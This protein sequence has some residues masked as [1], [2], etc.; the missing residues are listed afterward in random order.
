MKKVNPGVFLSFFR[1]PKIEKRRISLILD[2]LNFDSKG[3]VP[4]Q[5]GTDHNF[6]GSEFKLS[7]THPKDEL[8]INQMLSCSSL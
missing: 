7:W 4:L 3:P 5:I 6:L 8:I 2:L 1:L